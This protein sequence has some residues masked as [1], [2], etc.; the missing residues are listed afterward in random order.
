MD[1]REAS[2]GSTTVAAGSVTGNRYRDNFDALGLGPH[3]A[4]LADGMGDGP[5]SSF[6]SRT[7]VECFT[8]AAL[9]PGSDVPAVLRAAIAQ[10]H[11]RVRDFA[12]TT[13]GLAGCTL[14]GLTL[15]PD[16]A[17]L[18]Q[19][20]DSRAYRLRSGLLELL[21]TDHTAA[22]LGLLHGW[23]AASSPEA[24][25]A[26]YRLTRYVGHPDRPEPDVLSVTL[27]PGDTYLLCSDG[28][29]DQLPYDQI[30]AALTEASPALA[31]DA[32]L[33]GSLAAGGN[34]NATA[35]VIRA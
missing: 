16:G 29:S 34:D 17:W 23:Y 26:R 21:T 32:L 10:A 7:A 4:V 19:I 6:A 5:G 8:G 11:D 30:R 25:A 13:P 27:H 24:Q 14:T 1:L 35:I 33:T 3:V 20:G 28:V 15:G 18:T 9:G 31:V 2:W 12:R 22:W